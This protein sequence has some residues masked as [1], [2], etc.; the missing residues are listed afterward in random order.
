MDSSGNLIVGDDDG[1]P[2]Y[3]SSI[4]LTA[5]VTGT[6]YVNAGSYNSDHAGQYGV[7]VT[8]GTRASYD[9]EMGAGILLRE[10]A[11]WSTPGT[12]ATVTWAARTTDPG[13]V[14]AQGNPVVASQL[15]A[16]QVAAAHTMLDNYAQ[17]AGLTFTQVNP[18]GT[19]DNATIL[20][21]SYYSTTDGAGAYAYFPTGTPGNT[22]PDALDGDVRLNTDSVS[23]TSLPFGSYSYFAVLHELGHAMGLPHPGDYNAAPGVNITYEDF[24]QFRQDS[25]QYTIMSY[26]DESATGAHFQGYAQT[27]MMLDI[28][29]LQQ[30]YGVNYSTRAGNTT[31]GF[32]SNA[33][34]VYNFATN[35][36]PALCIWDG[37]GTDTLD[38]SGFSQNQT[39][40]LRAG[41]FSNVGGWIS[42][43]SIAYG[44]IIEN[45]IGGAGNDA[46]IGNAGNNVLNG[47]AGADTM[48]GGAGAD[49]YVVDSAGDIVDESVVDS[50]GFDRVQSALSINLADAAHFKGAIEMGVLLGS[51]NVNL[52]GNGLNNLLVGNAGNNYING[53]AGAD[54]MQGGAGND[55]YVVDSAGD[56]VDESVAGSNG[57]DRVQSALSINLADAAHFKGAIE[58][59]VLTGTSNSN[60]T[61]NAINNLLVGNAGN[62]YINGGAGADTMQG[63][64]GN[65][66]Y[67]VDSANDIV[68]ESVAGSNGFDRVQSALSI[69]LSDAAHFKGA[70][71][72]GVLTG[73]ANVNLTGNGLNNLLV[74]NAGDNF[75]NGGAGA[76][77]MQGG[78]GNDTYVVDNANDI[79]DE[80]VAGS[81]GFDR[82]QSTLTINLWD[83]AHVKGVVEMAVL[84]GTGNVNA[85]GGAINNLL[86]GNS[87]NN[88][89]NGGAG[90]DTL[91]GGAGHDTFAF[92]TAL[93]NTANVD[94]ITDFVAADDTILLENAIFTALTATGTLAASAFAIGA[95]TTAAQHILYN[96]TNGW[97]SYDADGSGA[98]AAI[99]FA[100]LSTHPTI[101]NADFVVV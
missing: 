76:D 80:S 99:H 53:G 46:I 25:Q 84:L 10:D 72:M 57:F 29:A 11:S 8:E 63:G 30:L 22:A 47:G 50:D 78:A 58:M 49:T 40:D 35:T 36:A 37:G 19:S 21:S 94:T 93:H 91:T 73:S 27:L 28:Y 24:A 23:T 92:T 20:F 48:Q 98:G 68:D 101:S 62:N 31:Y 1:G 90:N 3:N 54:T 87:G 77:T 26:F 89:L 61:G 14:D 39:I 69:N 100:T 45:A 17:V 15:T 33:G 41:H 55:T 59:A 70:I 65:D 71:E 9:E 16:A 5:N 52:T 66:T 18:G 2:G 85:S 75:I 13:A 12:P 95:A 82:I 34:G 97:L 96:A 74:G 83:T 79:V 64:A 7:S 44:A 88:V 43:V 51:A 38:V 60:L 86:V 42:N 32:H 67:V 56:I 81:N 4:T 6:Y